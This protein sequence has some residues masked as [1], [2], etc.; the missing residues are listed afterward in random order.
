MT[1]MTEQQQQEE[2]QLAGRMHDIRHKILVLSGKG[3]VGK[4]TVAVNLA[5]ALHGAGE[6]VG[7]LD[8]DIHGPSVPKM[9]GLEHVSARSS[10][11]GIVP[12]EPLPGFKVMSIGFLLANPSDAVVWRGPLKHHTIRQF[13]KDVEWGELD[14]LIIDSPPGTGDEP[15]SVAQSIPDADGA[16]L[17]T[18]PQQVAITD[19]RKCVTFCRN[20]NLPVLGVLENMSGLTCP[21]CGARV[22][23]FSTGGGRQ[24]AEE[25]EVA[26]L[27]AVPLDPRIVASGDSGSPFLSSCADSEAAQAFA[28]VVRH[29][30]DGTREG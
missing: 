14:Y 4:S 8:V 20:V 7:L 24:M 17:V 2:A 23:L 21:H 27:G 22:E 1:D 30:I 10:G 13:L 3:G 25:M 26:F 29:L 28:A 16:V 11:R 19:V 6:K 12:V 5:F 9:L 18:T 15:L